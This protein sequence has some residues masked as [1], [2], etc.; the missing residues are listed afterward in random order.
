MYCDMETVNKVN[1][2]PVDLIYTKIQNLLQCCN[3]QQS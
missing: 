2:K 3:V 1:K